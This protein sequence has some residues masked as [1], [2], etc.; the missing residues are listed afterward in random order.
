LW[1]DAPVIFHAQMHI[2]KMKK[3][4]NR[5]ATENTKK[6]LRVLDFCCSFFVFSVFSVAIL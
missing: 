4:H 5:M 3:F 2:G 6:S 1:I